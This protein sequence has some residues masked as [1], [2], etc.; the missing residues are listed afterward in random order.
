MEWAGRR[1]ERQSPLRAC[2]SQP[3]IDDRAS[4]DFF[5]ALMMAIVVVY[6]SATERLLTVSKRP[7]WSAGGERHQADAEAC[8]SLHR[9]RRTIF[10]FFC[11]PMMPTSL[12]ICRNS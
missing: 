8:G 1:R 3:S 9:K 11:P 6:I 7:S 5:G 12:V 4:F 2:G 10:D